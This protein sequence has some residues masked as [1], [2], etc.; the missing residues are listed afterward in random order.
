MAILHWATSRGE[1]KDIEERLIKYSSKRA[2]ALNLAAEGTGRWSGHFNCLYL[3]WSLK[4]SSKWKEQTK[5]IPIFKVEKMWEFDWA[6][7]VYPLP[8]GI[9]KP[10]HLSCALTAGQAEAAYKDL[11]WNDE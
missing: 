2:K 5:V 11:N 9:F 10:V 8:P 6:H 7:R 1:S 4:S 3:C